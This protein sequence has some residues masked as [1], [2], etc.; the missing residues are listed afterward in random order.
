MEKKKEFNGHKGIF[1]FRIDLDFFHPKHVEKTLKAAEKHEIDMTWFVNMETGQFHEREIKR[2]AKTQD[3]QNH[4]FLHETFKDSVKNF[5]NIMKGDKLLQEMGVK[6]SGFAAPFGFWNKELGSAL[7][8]TGYEYSSEFRKG[9]NIFPFYPKGNGKK[10]KVL[11]VPIHP[12]CLG[13]LFE[14]GYNEKE[15][16]EYFDKII[17][18]LYEKQIP[19][20]LYG[21]P[22]GRIGAH[23]K[24][25]EKIFEKV[26]ELD[27]VWFTNLTEYAN[28]WKKKKFKQRKTTWNEHNVFVEAKKSKNRKMKSFYKG[29]LM[30]V[31]KKKISRRLHK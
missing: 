3:V 7:E 15:A 21:H 26:K 5:E 30:R 16:I 9:K 20:F 1:A 2:I 29:Q 25:L 11:Q 23:P 24:V 18:L 8:K 12:I 31:E 22:T 10:S 4:A 27:D 13:S 17:K 28:F 14:S 19:I 6:C